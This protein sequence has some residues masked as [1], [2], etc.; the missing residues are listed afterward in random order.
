MDDLKI[1]DLIESWLNGNLTDVMAALH[2]NPPHFT[3]LMTRQLYHDHGESEV[4][5]FVNLLTDYCLAKEG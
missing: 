1:T 5:R 2:K 3:A 4:N